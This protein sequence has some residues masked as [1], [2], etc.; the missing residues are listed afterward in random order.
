MSRIQDSPPLEASPAQPK[1]KVNERTSSW[2]MS[3]SS[4]A[5]PRSSARTS[6]PSQHSREASPPPQRQFQQDP[7]TLPVA[8]PQ[9]SSQL[10]TEVLPAVTAGQTELSIWDAPVS[11]A[12]T[13]SIQHTTPQQSARN[14]NDSS[15]YVGSNHLV[16]KG[17]GEQDVL[18]VP[19]PIGKY[20]PSW[21]PYNATPIVEEEGFQYEERS[22][23]Q[24]PPIPPAVH[25]LDTPR[26]PIDAKSDRSA[27]GDT[28]F[29]DAPEQPADAD[30]WVIISKENVPKLSELS[31]TA[32]AALQSNAMTQSNSV[33]QPPAGFQS[34]G[35]YQAPPVYQPRPGFQPV[36]GYQPPVGY[37]LP[38]GYQPPAAQQPPIGY[39][40]PAGYQL[41]A[42]YQPTTGFQPSAGPP[43][44]SQPPA[45]S[46]PQTSSQGGFRGRFI[47]HIRQRSSKDG[48]MPVAGQPSTPPAATKTQP[49]KENKIVENR[50]TEFVGLPPIRRSST[51]G[52]GFRTKDPNKRFPLDDEEE[53]GIQQELPGALTS[54]R[55]PINQRQDI[56]S[57]APT[58]S[59]VGGTDRFD[60]RVSGV[61]VALGATAITAAVGD[62]MNQPSGEPSRYYSAQDVKPT[63]APDENQQRPALSNISSEY[64]RPSSFSPVSPPLSS[65]VSPPGS[66]PAF[67]G[68]ALREPVG[69]TVGQQVNTQQI[70]AGQ[71]R[72][73]DAEWRLN[74]R[75][76]Q[77]QG[78][79]PPASYQRS[80]PAEMHQSASQVPPVAVH[81]QHPSFEGQRPANPPSH[82]RE[83]S[84]EG[85][86]VHSPST[87][88]QGNVGTL[89]VLSRGVFVPPPRAGSNQQKPF[90]QPPSSAQRYPAL[91]RAEHGGKESSVDGLPAHYY[92]A[93]ISK[94]DAFLPRQQTNEYQLPGVGP[95][96]DQ[97]QSGKRNSRRNSA[98]LKEL[99]GRLSR[100]ASRDRDST[101]DDDARSPLRPVES[102]DSQ[103]R[104]Y[105]A[106]SIASEDTVEKKKRKSGMSFFG[107]L[108]RE[109]AGG[110]PQS[111]E[112]M[113][114]HLPGSRTDS[115]MQL[116]PQQPSSPL[117]PPDKRKLFSNS[118]RSTPDPEKSNQNKLLRASTSSMMAEQPGKKKRFSG[119]TSMFSKPSMEQQRRSSSGSAGQAAQDSRNYQQPAPLAQGPQYLEYPAQQ[120]TQESRRFQEVARPMG[121]GGP[122]PQAPP[123][124]RQD[125]YARGPVVSGYVGQSTSEP[126]HIAQSSQGP[127]RQESPA[128]RVGLPLPSP[129]LVNPTLQHSVIETRPIQDRHISQQYSP[130]LQSPQSYQRQTA[131]VTQSG[132]PPQPGTNSQSPQTHQRQAS[133]VI[134]PGQLSQPSPDLQSLQSHQRQT[135]GVT[136]PGPISQPVPNSQSPLNHP[137]QTSVES[138]SGPL[139]QSVP[140]LQSPPNGLQQTPAVTQLRPLSQ[141]VT[142]SQSRPRQPSLG[143]QPFPMSQPPTSQSP[144][145]F[146]ENRASYQQGP[147][148]A[149][150]GQLNLPPLQVP[151]QGQFQQRVP[152][153][154]Q[155]ANLR[156]AASPQAAPRTSQERQP[157]LTKQSPVQAN[158]TKA[159][160]KQRQGSTARLLSGL[161]GGRRSSGQQ[162]KDAAD[163]RMGTAPQMVT[164]PPGQQQQRQ[165]QLQQQLPQQWQQQQQMSPNS[166]LQG[167]S[168]QNQQRGRPM[169]QEPQYDPLPIPNAYNLVRGEGGQLVPTPY[170]PR[171]LNAQPGPYGNQQ[172]IYRDQAHAYPPRPPQIQIQ[173]YSNGQYGSMN[174]S[175]AP[176]IAPVA[177]QNTNIDVRPGLDPLQNPQNS[178]RS[179]RPLTNEDL[180]AR[181]PARPQ[182]GQ[183]APYQL[184]LPDENAGN[185]ERDRP[186]PADKSVPSERQPPLNGKLHM[187]KDLP[188]ERNLPVERMFPP[189]GNINTNQ[190]AA[191]PSLR[192]PLSPATYPLPE[193]APFS[194]I[195]PKADQIPPPPPPKWPQQATASQNLDRS[196]TINTHA[197]E[198]S[199]ISGGQ[200]SVPGSSRPKE[201]ERPTSVTPP[202]PQVTPERSPEQV[203]RHMASHP[204][205]EDVY[206]AS[207]RHSVVVTGS[208]TT[209]SEAPQQSPE[210]ILVEGRDSQNARRRTSQE[211]KI[212]VEEGM[213]RPGSAQDEIPSMSAT[214]YPGQEWHPYGN[215]YEDWD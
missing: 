113:V 104:D 186:L 164:T 83:P 212:L 44:T 114:T 133:G 205:E 26:I 6:T 152:G 29:F 48:N 107:A 190:Q 144:S 81:P 31:F 105:S 18:G 28:P 115:L 147:P 188:T 40:P 193:H 163:T 94:E 69:P 122:S 72:R 191:N 108:R 184:S 70:Y 168:G 74:A 116:Q 19:A 167:M 63:Q 137:H 150:G 166:Q 103:S 132:P 23:N 204:Q 169:N 111:R 99:G 110:P 64:S 155:Q 151:Q 201:Q 12:S 3:L 142:N 56:N 57:V 98:L 120:T 15:R 58:V 174:H 177:P 146:T 136:Q 153:D 124:N 178:S 172:Y 118:N 59:Q 207:P 2:N 148:A 100:S 102:R 7:E 34:S 176:Q 160:N 157:V 182:F 123:Q 88:S 75:I 42:G 189:A 91:F 121:R 16:S 161:I 68:G 199:Q 65:P 187:E 175:N 135:S 14:E 170:D 213:V 78:T 39:Q 185:D 97:P 180:V 49:V 82:A 214:S 106:A 109:S 54:E 13:P 149:G 9:Q 36:A 134:Q 50:P 131:G 128:G 196:N 138:P 20:Q 200:L 61:E 198:V 51:F 129:S 192:H 171:G 101:I 158:Q 183:Q 130:N 89:P 202:S 55:D 92:Q 139:P 24:P 5:L 119:I 66:R 27:R 25:H 145:Q 95:P 210:K 194:P 85:Q 93:P 165:P 96:P 126:I 22:S 195:N 211:E 47:Q 179:T 143:T 17:E 53:D 90:D 112:S 41:P 52:L 173:P 77:E 37:Q 117:A 79:A 21:D 38:A 8:T 86:R 43:T 73:P 67:T 197:S 209:A 32:P 127:Q 11:A 87:S 181:S 203:S 10:G 206:S 76:S 125:H 215:G 159:E 46:Q 140:S 156:P 154:S 71:D 33:N 141:P 1:P 30:D 45:A 35:M 62:R 4:L 84:F 60:S 208:A 80:P 162:G